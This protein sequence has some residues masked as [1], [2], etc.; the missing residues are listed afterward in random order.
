MGNLYRF[1]YSA[2][3]KGKLKYIAK[4]FSPFLFHRPSRLLKQV[5]REI[6]EKGIG[7]IEEG[8][9]KEE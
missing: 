1:F 6:I 4:H 2:Q 3:K 9:D 5:Y 8:N 7:K